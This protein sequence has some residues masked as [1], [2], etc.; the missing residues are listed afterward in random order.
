MLCLTGVE[1]G[2]LIIIVFVCTMGNQ[3]GM[4]IPIIKWVLPRHPQTKGAPRYQ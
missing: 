1:N 3:A 4:V 2:L